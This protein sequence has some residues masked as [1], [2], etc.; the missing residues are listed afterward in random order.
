M[1]AQGDLPF[2]Y[3]FSNGDDYNSVGRKIFGD[4]VWNEAS[5]LFDEDEDGVNYVEWRDLEESTPLIFPEPDPLPCVEEFNE[6][7]FV[8]SLK[9][10][11]NAAIF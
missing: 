9:V 4:E 1:F 10:E 11:K 6:G 3:S 7:N 5:R 2:Y 8:V